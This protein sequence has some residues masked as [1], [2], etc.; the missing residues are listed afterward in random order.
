MNSNPLTATG[1][2]SYWDNIKG[3][4]IALVIF[5]H[6]LFNFTDRTA[7]NYIVEAIYF[8]HMPAFVFVSGYFSKSKNSGSARSLVRLM[9]AYLLLTAVHLTMAFINNH[10]LSVT[11][12]Y[13]S[14]WYLLALVA[15][16]LITPFFSK[17]KWSLLLFLAVS[18][19]AGL[20]QD[21]DNQFAF[22]R[23]I[24][25]YP[26]FLAGYFFSKERK[27]LISYHPSKKYPWEFSALPLPQR[28]LTLRQN[29]CI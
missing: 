25:L 20:W 4:L 19:L 27:S 21:I 18:M 29:I 1:R 13:N 22:A 8:F 9:S 23:I 15:W 12:P 2:S 11:V 7:V 17:S 3:V 6:C 16:R 5:G 28:R 24:S 10:E 26:F 14:A